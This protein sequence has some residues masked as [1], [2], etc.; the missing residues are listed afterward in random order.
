MIECLQVTKDSLNSLSNL[1]MGCTCE[2]FW[3]LNNSKY[4][5]SDDAK[6]IEEKDGEL[7]WRREIKQINKFCELLT[8][9]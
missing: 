8:L 7:V 5:C 2:L 4:N 6:T 9:Y 1:R 3:I